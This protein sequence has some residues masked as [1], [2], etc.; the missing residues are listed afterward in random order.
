MLRKGTYRQGQQVAHGNYGA[1]GG[2]PG[3]D[4]TVNNTRVDNAANVR[5]D[6]SANTRVTVEPV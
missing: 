5:V 1:G 2:G 6:N 3:E 4:I